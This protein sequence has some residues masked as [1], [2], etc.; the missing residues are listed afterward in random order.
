MF[1][2]VPTKDTVNTMRGVFYRLLPGECKH[3]GGDDNKWWDA[4]K[5]VVKTTISKKRTTV[6]MAMKKAFVSK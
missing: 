4:V 5:K 2:F 1:E 3:R 6:T